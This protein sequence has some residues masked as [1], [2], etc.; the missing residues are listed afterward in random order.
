M[1]AQGK[2]LANVVKYIIT[3]LDDNNAAVFKDSLGHLA[4]VHNAR[5]VTADH[6]SVMG[7]C[8]IH[9]VRICCGT[10]FFTDAHK[11]AWVHIYSK[12]MNV[13]IPVVVAGTIPDLSDMDRPEQFGK[14]AYMK[15]AQANLNSEGDKVHETRLSKEREKEEKLRKKEEKARK[16]AGKMDAA[17]AQLKQKDPKDKDKFTP[18]PKVNGLMSM[19]TEGACPMTGA[20]GNGSSCPMA[21]KQRGGTDLDDID[22]A[23]Q[24]EV[25]Q[26]LQNHFQES[27]V[28]HLNQLRQAHLAQQ[29][30]EQHLANC[31]PADKYKHLKRV[32]GVAQQVEVQLRDQGAEAITG[33][34]LL[35][36][37]ENSDLV[38]S[39]LAALQTANYF[40]QFQLMQV[41][42]VSAVAGDEVLLDRAASS[43]YTGSGSTAGGLPLPT[44][45]VANESTIY[46][47][48]TQYN[49][50][51]SSS[52]DSTSDN[53]LRVGGLRLNTNNINGSSSDLLSPIATRVPSA[54]GAGSALPPM[55]PGPATPKCYVRTLAPS[56]VITAFDTPK[57]S[58]TNTSVA[59]SSVPT[60]STSPPPMMLEEQQ[61]L[62]AHI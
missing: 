6:Y 26:T 24:M 20:K 42:Q 40:L 15:S 11:D 60:P 1:A 54:L 33:A 9:T 41:V 16:K 8:L 31:T 25:S 36:L 34:Q 5:G 12:M 43:T 56:N 45:F 37:L 17:N 47:F 32:L 23:S 28:E 46:S 21:N 59:S 29:R 27:A 48:G 51:S 58:S 3:N 14:S 39:H 7:M 62:S 13:I 35:A 52:A 22:A 18:A 2:M 19:D 61:R 10:K 38:G 53:H 57:D 30:E 49:E 55:A 4:R 44:V 50:P